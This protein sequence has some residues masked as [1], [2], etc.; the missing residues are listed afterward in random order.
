[1]GLPAHLQFPCQLKQTVPLKDSYGVWGTVVPA[2]PR[3]SSSAEQA[4]VQIDS[5]QQLLVPTDLLV[6]QSD[7]SYCLPLRISVAERSFSF[8]DRG[9]MFAQPMPQPLLHG[10]RQL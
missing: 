8:L 6:Q 5:G 1:M 4:V 7:G 3:R 9:Q 10:S 2:S